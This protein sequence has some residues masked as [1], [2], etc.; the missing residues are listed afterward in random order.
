MNILIIGGGG[1]EHVITKYIARNPKAT[2][3]YALPGNAGISQFAECVNI[4]AEDINGMISFAQ[5]HAI[6]FAI[7]AP[8]DPLA[9]GAVD[10]LEEIGIKCFGP[11]QKAAQIE[12]SKV[13]AKDLMRKHNIPT[14]KYEVFTDIDAALSYVAISDCPIVIKADGLAKGKGVTVAENFQQAREAIMSCMKAKTFGKSGERII[15]EECLTGPEVTVLAFTDGK[16]IVPM[17]SSMDHKRAYDGNKGPNTGGMGVIAPNPY[18]TPQIADECMKRI[19]LPTIAAMNEEGHKFKGC[20][21]FGLMLTKDGPKVI[22]YNCRFGDPEAEAVLPLM[23]SDLLEVMLAVSDERLCG[24]GATPLSASRVPPTL[25]GMSSAVRQEGVKFRKGA[26]CCVV[27]A[28]SGY[29]G[30][31]LTGYPID[32]GDADDMAGV[33]IFHAGTKSEGGKILTAGGRV[34]AVNA[35]GDDAESSRALAYEA[36]SRISF[37]GMRYRSDIGAN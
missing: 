28:S 8:D 35:V 1:R 17:I 3:I 24:Y 20:L 7:V 22:E 18:Y 26:S 30:H 5:S 33:E 11:S 4:S 15:I 14:A 13:F 27:C 25:G 31:Y 36:V 21:Y 34:L 32:F 6:D 2:K 12:S 37:E 19:F 16:T 10:R 29:P 23:E 9:L